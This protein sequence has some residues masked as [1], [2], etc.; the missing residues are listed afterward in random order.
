MGA[1]VRFYDPFADLL[2]VDGRELVSETDLARAVAAA[3][4]VVLLQAHDQIVESSDLDHAALIL[5]T[6]GVLAG[7]NIERL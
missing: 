7:P 5:D 1:D 2:M 3:D 6:R 4:L